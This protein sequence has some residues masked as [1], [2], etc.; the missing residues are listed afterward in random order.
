V[1]RIPAWSPN[2]FPALADSSV[3]CIVSDEDSRIA[4]LTPAIATGS[5]V[6]EAGQSAPPT[7]RTKK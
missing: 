5:S 3:Q 4:V 1:V 7:T 6:S 2:R